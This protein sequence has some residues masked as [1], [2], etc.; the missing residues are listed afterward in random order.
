LGRA[1]S[2]Q[3][4]LWDMMCMYLPT[5]ANSKWEHARKSQVH[6]NQNND[7]NSKNKNTKRIKKE[8]EDAVAPK[9]TWRQTPHILAKD[10]SNVRRVP[11][12]N[13]PQKPWCDVGDD[14]DGDIWR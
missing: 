5:S 11:S 6:H 8:L 3:L 12:K 14:N 2:K 13:I 4:T 7:N 10:K 9:Q 1:A